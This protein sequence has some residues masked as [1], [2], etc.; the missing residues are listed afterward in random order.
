MSFKISFKSPER[1]TVMEVRRQRI[2]ESRSR[3]CVHVVIVWLVKNFGVVYMIL[4]LHTACSY[5]FGQE[6]YDSPCHES[7][8]HS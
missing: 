2:P 7:R 5:G 4:A 3:H 8:P 6:L 1:R